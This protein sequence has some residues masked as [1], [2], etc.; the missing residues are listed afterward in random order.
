MDKSGP[1]LP[2][3]R[4]RYNNPEHVD[5]LQWSAVQVLEAYYLARDPA[6]LKRAKSSVASARNEA[7]TGT[8]ATPTSDT[9]Q[10][11]ATRVSHALA[12]RWHLIGAGTT[13]AQGRAPCLVP[14]PSCAPHA[15]PV[16][17]ECVPFL[18]RRAAC[19]LR[20]AAA[21]L[22]AAA[23]APAPMTSTSAP[24]PA[25]V[26]AR[27][28]PRAPPMT[29]TSAPAPPG[30]VP[31]PAPVHARAT[32]Q[33]PGAPPMTSTSVPAPAP[34]AP[35]PAPAPVH[36]RATLR[37]PPMTSTSAPSTSVP[38][39]APVPAPASAPGPAPGP[40]PAPAPAPGPSPVQPV[41]T[42]ESLTTR[43]GALDRLA[44]GACPRAEWVLDRDHPSVGPLLRRY[45]HYGV[46]SLRY[47]AGEWQ[48]TIPRITLHTVLHPT[49]GVFAREVNFKPRGHIL[50]T[51]PGSASS[52]LSRSKSQ[53]DFTSS[54]RGGFDITAV[55]VGFDPEAEGVSWIAGD[56]GACLAV[57]SGFL[58][59]C[60]RGTLSPCCLVCPRCYADIGLQ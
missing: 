39:P 8:D 34:P 30:P 33:A 27:A 7:D 55:P 29:S 6:A 13:C 57:W 43:A 25:P 36:A 28:T 3:D 10:A 26:H 22:S 48:F 42:V 1:L 37:V 56:P 5:G 58:C 24:A 38:A 53:E 40:A 23:P 51:E 19:D 14:I 35:N 11:L 31:A 59:L 32:L 16:S 49:S 41:D 50:R 44:A 20:L 17:D 45:A 18:L 9:D 54:T 21:A 12:L 47:A 52:D 15:L 2:P 60:A 4:V 46:A